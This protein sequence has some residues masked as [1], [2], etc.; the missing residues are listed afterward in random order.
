MRVL[1]SHCPVRGPFH[2]PY[3]G[4]EFKTGVSQLALIPDV[5]IHPLQVVAVG[6]LENLEPYLVDQEFTMTDCLRAKI[7]E[8]PK[9]HWAFWD[10]IAQRYLP[11]RGIATRGNARLNAIFDWL[12]ESVIW[13]T[14]RGD[15]RDPSFSIERSE[16]AWV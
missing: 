3:L 10:F 11:S 13:R 2:F 14:Y 4:A 6:D 1:L 8:D 15:Y 9:H 7:Y 16:H 5:Q 12:V